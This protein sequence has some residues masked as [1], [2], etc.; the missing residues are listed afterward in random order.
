MFNRRPRGE[1]V[2]TPELR[3]NLR[4]L[5]FNS[6]IA[7]QW[8]AARRRPNHGDLPAL[9]RRVVEKKTRR[10]AASG[11]PAPCPILSSALSTYR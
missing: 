3:S 4:G 5:H 6:V 11:I 2:I 8:V 7:V 9:V 1:D 10:L